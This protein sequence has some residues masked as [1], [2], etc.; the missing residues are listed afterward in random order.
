M[1]VTRD[2]RADRA[3]W[4]QILK[5]KTGAGLTRMESHD[6]EADISR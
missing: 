3:S 5:R 6:P 4:I 1:L 2:W